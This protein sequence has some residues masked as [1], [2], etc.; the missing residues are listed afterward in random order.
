[1]FE[2]ISIKGKISVILGAA[3]AGLALIAVVSLFGLRAEMMKDRQDKTRSVVEVAHSLVAHYEEM[4]RKGTLARDAAQAAAKDALRRLRYAG[5]EYFFITDRSQRMIM[6]PIRPEMDGQDQSRTADPNGKLL[7]VEMTRVGFAA[8]GGFVDYLWPKPGN[9]EPVPKISYVRGF[10]PWGWLIGSGIYVD[11]VAAAFREA[12]LFL[13]GLGLLIGLVATGIALL[14]SRA[15]VLPLHT[16]T[17]VMQT[18]AN[19]DTAVTVNGTDR[20]DE[21]GVMARTVEIF[22]KNQIDLQRHWERRQVEHRVTGQRARALERLTERFDATVSAMVGTVGKAV[23]ALEN[24]ARSLSDTADRNMREAASVAGASQQAS[25]NVQTVAS[26]AEELSSAIAE[27]GTQVATSSHI[28]M[29]AVHASRLASDRIDGLGHAAQ[30]INEV[31]DLITSIA[32]QTN[33][34]ALNATIEAARAG[35]MGKGFAV[36]AGEVKNLAG[37]TAKATEEIAAQI[38]EV[39]QASQGAVSAIR[40]IAGIIARSDEIGTSI[41]AA[42]QQQ[43]AATGEIARSAGEAAQGTQQVST[44]IDE[45]S[46]SALETEKAANSLLDAAESLAQEAGSLRNLVDAFL[47][48]VEAIN[49]AELASLFAPAGEDVFMPWND[50]LAVGQE[51]IDNDH[52]I[53]VALIN[54]AAR[55]IRGG[56]VPHAIG[57]AIDQLVAYTVLHFEQEER[58]MERSAYPD[59]VQHKAQHDALRKRVAELKQRFESGEARVGDDLLALFR[60]WLTG[61]IQR[62]DKRIGSHLEGRGG[63]DQP[64]AAVRRAA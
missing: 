17:G 10:E 42:V 27:I 46:A 62:F 22:R 3:A 23:Q 43:G 35:E 45:V 4:E 9:A 44:S 19:G 37:Q 24:T 56:E 28:S 49:S 26:A 58:V 57:S 16:M 38:N 6:H 52:M 48:N 5:S 32:S 55:R 1:M 12:A 61:H 11:D 30:K 36:V 60:D 59:F 7:F 13:G 51:D 25:V 2:R 15:I 33:L 34:L 20:G 54:R 64:A 40:E 50:T 31:A 63:N 18:L 8:E 21:I 53:L 47:V 41:A 14:V 39:Q 29:Q